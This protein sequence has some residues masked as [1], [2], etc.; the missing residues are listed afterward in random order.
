M[1]NYQPGSVI[2]MG[3]PE[4]RIGNQQNRIIVITRFALP[5]YIKLCLPG[6]FIDEPEKLLQLFDN[7]VLFL[8]KSDYRS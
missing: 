2:K 1:A 6:R 8:H 7:R 5:S 4:Y 3:N